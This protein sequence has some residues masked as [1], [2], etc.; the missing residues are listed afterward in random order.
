MTC[1]KVRHLH[2]G[3][4]T[5]WKYNY[6][7]SRWTWYCMKHQI[8]VFCFQRRVMAP[9]LHSLCTMSHQIGFFLFR[10]TWLSLYCISVASATKFCS[11]VFRGTYIILLILQSAWK[12]KEFKLNLICFISQE[13]KSALQFLVH[14]TPYNFWCR[15]TL[16]LFQ[17]SCVPLTFI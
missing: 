15:I 3:S 2:Y 4:R 1:S 11:F 17:A 8:L 12:A 10:D 14:S 5:W 16:L 9:T 13:T 6:Y 7:N